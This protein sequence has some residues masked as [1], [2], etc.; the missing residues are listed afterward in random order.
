MGG[1]PEAP[2]QKPINAPFLYS[3]LEKQRIRHSE[4]DFKTDVEIEFEPRRSI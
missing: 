3:Q 1:L 4:S 2:A